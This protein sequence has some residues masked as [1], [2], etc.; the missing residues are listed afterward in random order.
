M[1]KLT[2]EEKEALIEKYTKNYPDKTKEQILEIMR[3]KHYDV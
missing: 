3:H 2:K 1:I